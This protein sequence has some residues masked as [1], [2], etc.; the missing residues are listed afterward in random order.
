MSVFFSSVTLFSITV[1]FRLQTIARD[2]PPY[3]KGQD[4][5]QVVIGKGELWALRSSIMG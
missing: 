1:G 3:V 2:W 4:S 5:P